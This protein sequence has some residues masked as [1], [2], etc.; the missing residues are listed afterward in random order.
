[1]KRRIE[2]IE[3]NG[4]KWVQLRRTKL[5][6]LRIFITPKNVMFPT[7]RKLLSGDSS[8]VNLMT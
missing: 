1:M 5:L 3:R 2:K 6:T 8:S 7:V 4:G